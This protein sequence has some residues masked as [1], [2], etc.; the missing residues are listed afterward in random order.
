M[1]LIYIFGIIIAL[2]F[3]ILIARHFLPDKAKEK[4]C[5]ICLA[6]TLTWIGLL[7]SYWSGIFDN[8]IIISLLMGSTILGIFY[9]VEKKVK[10]ELTVFRLPFLLTLF[11]IGYSALTISIHTS[12]LFFLVAFWIFFI[13]IYSYKNNKKINSFTNKIVECCKKW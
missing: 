13:L 3:L 5:T 1:N 10:K 11:F 2:F 7:V 4:L 8:L 6:V 9:I 12:T